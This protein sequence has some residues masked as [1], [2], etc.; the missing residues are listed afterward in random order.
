MTYPLEVFHGIEC[1]SL[2]DPV[3]FFRVPGMTFFDIPPFKQLVMYPNQDKRE[4]ERKRYFSKLSE[5][6]QLRRYAGVS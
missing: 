4:I 2:I 6:I 5:D 1:L 3:S